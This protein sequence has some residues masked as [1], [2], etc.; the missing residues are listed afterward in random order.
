RTIVSPFA[1]LRDDTAPKHRKNQIITDECLV[2]L[3]QRHDDGRID[4]PNFLRVHAADRL[5]NYESSHSKSIKSNI[6]KN[7]TTRILQTTKD[8]SEQ[9]EDLE[10]LKQM[11]L[12]SK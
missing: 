11:L 12:N 7:M 2:K 8:G 4:I 6:A 1:R 5:L 10:I 9:K 3:W